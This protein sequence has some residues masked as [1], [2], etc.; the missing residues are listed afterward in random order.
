MK[1][2][3]AMDEEEDLQAEIARV[4]YEI[5]QR[6]GIPGLDVENWREAERLVLARR[7]DR[8]TSE[9][10]KKTVSSRGKGGTAK[11]K[12]KSEPGA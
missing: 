8:K 7:Q 12:K 9:A 2:E 5:Y 6:V 1:E 11:R 4:A 10:A 3:D